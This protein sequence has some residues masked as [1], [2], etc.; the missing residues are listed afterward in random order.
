MLVHE[1]KL[2]LTCSFMLYWDF[3]IYNLFYYKSKLC[4]CV[5]MHLRAFNHKDISLHHWSV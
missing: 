1:R 5:C 3:T 2:T 4:V